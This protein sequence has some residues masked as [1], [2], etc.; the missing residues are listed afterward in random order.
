M[1]Q[2][3]L[4]REI[5]PVNNISYLDEKYQSGKVQGI[6]M[7]IQVG[8]NYNLERLQYWLNFELG[9]SAL[10]WMSWLY[11]YTLYLAVIAAVIFIPFLLRVLYE[12]KRQGWFSSFFIV[13]AGIPLLL[14]LFSGREWI[15][16]LIAIGCF[17]SYCAFLR[18]VIPE[19]M[20]EKEFEMI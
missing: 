10:F 8:K 13:V 9:S 15:A 12:E 20:M 7:E 14:Y 11:T 4:V 1:P 18:L 19:W 2:K 16:G 3:I 6:S 5:A 17:Y